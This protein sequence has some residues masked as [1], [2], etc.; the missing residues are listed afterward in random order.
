MAVNGINSRFCNSTDI[1]D[2][3]NKNFETI[4]RINERISKSQAG[5]L[6]SVICN[7]GFL[8]VE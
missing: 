6:G 5:T 3:M 2:V 1:A 7:F 8:Q 4:L